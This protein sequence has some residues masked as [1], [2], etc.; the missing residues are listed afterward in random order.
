MTNSQWQSFLGLAH[1]A[2]K[3]I[4]GEDTVI[5]A[6]K[7][8][9]AVVVILSEDASDRT[10]KTINNKCNSYRVPIRTVP[11]REGLGQAIGQHARVLVAV[12][13]KGFANKL[14]ALLD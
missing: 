1:R 8:E 2:G 13:D 9:K 12:T 14:I 10:K 3:V 6:V 4:S 7:Q 5:R 11:N